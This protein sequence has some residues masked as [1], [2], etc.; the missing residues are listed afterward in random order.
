MA[1]QTTGDRVELAVAEVGER[2]PVHRAQLDGAPAEGGDRGQLPA[3]VRRGLVA[4]PGER[5]PT[6][7]WHAGSPAQIRLAA[8]IRRTT[9]TP[10]A[11]CASLSVSRPRANRW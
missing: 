6:S 9:S 1:G 10:R 5:Y 11:N 2:N 7:G 8:P 4:D 3:Q